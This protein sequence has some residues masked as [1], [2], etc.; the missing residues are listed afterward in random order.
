MITKSVS[1]VVAQLH[2]C[3][4]N[5]LLDSSLLT[6][7][8]NN[9]IPLNECEV[10]D[11]K[12]QL[13]SSDLEYAKTI[14]DLI[15]FYNSYGGFLVFGIA[16]TTKDR[17][18]NIVGLSETKINIAK[19]RDMIHNYLGTNLRTTVKSIRASNSN[20]EVVWI[21]KRLGRDA[22][23]KFIK[24][25]PEYKPGKPCFKRSEIVFRRLE[26]NAIAITP[27]DY[28]FLY[29]KRRPPSIELS[30]EEGDTGDQ[31]EHNLPDRALVC[32]QFVGR[33]EDLSVLWAWL[34]DDFSRVRLIAGEGG[35][36]KT[37]LAYR[38]AE[39]VASRKIK[40]FEQIIWITAKKRQFIPAEDTYRENAWTDFHD[41][42][43]LFCAIAAAHGCI[44]ND[45]E[46]LSSRELMQ[47]A[48]E[49][50]A[51]WP[52]LI[53]VDDVD[54]LSTE[55]QKRALELGMRTPSNTKMLLTSRVNFS[56]SPDNVL[57]LNGLSEEEF[58]KYVQVVRD[59]YKLPNIKDPKLRQLR[60]V[61][62]GSPL[63]TDSLLRLE[64]GG[65]LLEQAIARWKNE[66]GLEVRKAALQREVEQLSKQAKR[67]L[68]VISNARSA[69][70]VEL[71]QILQYTEQ[72]LGDALQ[73]LAGLFLVSSPSIGREAR[74]TVEPN[75]GLLVLELGQTLG[76]DH[77]ALISALS[78]SRTDAVGISREKRSNL[79]GQA[80][81]EAIAFMRNGDIASGLNTVI[82]ASKKLKKPNADLLLAIG[83]FSLQLSPPDRE[84]ASK[85]F[86]QSYEL[87]QRKKLLF[88]LWFET[89]YKRQDF[90]QALRV[91]T[92]A[93]DYRIDDLASWYERRAQIHIALAHKS[94]SR[95]LF[96]AA[97]RE[98]KAAIEDLWNARKAS[99]GAIQYRRMDSLLEQAQFLKSKLMRV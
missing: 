95:V 38:F 5:G 37:S 75:T 77:T 67:A 40:P 89:E 9:E 11:F 19:L 64:R 59:R 20:L 21:E 53:V 96:D 26:N 94:N 56:Y 69:S 2:K 36:G 98:V 12:Q 15:A 72:T 74:Y 78:R 29:S 83:R 44:K 92:D 45:F 76:I 61:T 90:D 23:L 35:L 62:G 79:V 39:D 17:S 52:S 86:S 88:D 87:G 3:A 41:A 58:V 66:K 22:P 46:N 1:E 70:F 57:K 16:E 47:L 93:I 24:N 6:Y 81:N 7:I 91:T 71:L 25:G 51:T 63:F 18:F 30:I 32:Q 10:L 49:S 27:E 33:H 73:E 8:V 60:D 68:Y 84:R 48:V 82:S 55:D 50:C 34:S 54:S 65:L 28:A 14:R 42:D 80:I 13:P 43:S 4:S 99:N 97:I 85:A 31:L